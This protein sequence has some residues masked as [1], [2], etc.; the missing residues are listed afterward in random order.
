M[1]TD[2]PEGLTIVEN[3]GGVDFGYTHKAA[4][5]NLGMDNADGIWVLDEYYESGRT[6]LEV[7]EYVAAKGFSRVYPDPESPAAIEEMR[8]KGVN[9]RPV[10]KGKDSE[11]HGID[12][13]RERLKANKL[14]IHRSCVGLINEF[15]THSYK[16]D[17]VTPE[18]TG[19]DA[20]DA[21]RYPIFM[22]QPEPV[23]KAYKFVPDEAI[24]SSIG[25]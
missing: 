7:A 19:E 15:E 17:G 18:T 1:F 9:I 22:L 25:L 8:R 16:E 21:L 14:H 4:V 10:V 5:L 6:D 3:I 13:I 23:R 2:L 24:F 11:S 20:L 12:R